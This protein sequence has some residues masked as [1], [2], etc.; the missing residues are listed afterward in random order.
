MVL[1]PFADYFDH[2]DEGCSVE[3]GPK[4]FKISSDRVYERDDEIYISYGSHSN[5]FLLAEYGFILPG[6]KWDEIQLDHILLAELSTRQRYQLEE[7]GF[8]GKYALDH[9]T[10]C[11]RTHVALR[12]IVYH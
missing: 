11:H 7:L 3:Y 10:V 5:D 12:L 9:G 2:A 6:N 1:N 4:G 8:L